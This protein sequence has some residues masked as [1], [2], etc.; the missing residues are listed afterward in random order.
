VILNRRRFLA[1]PLAHLMTR[2]AA[3]TAAVDSAWPASEWSHG[4]AEGSGWDR[5]WL[6]QARDYSR[7]IGTASF[8]LL[9]HGRVIDSWGDTARRIEIH[10]IRKSLLN[11]LIGVAVS[12]G[13]L[14]LDASLASL[15]IDDVPPALSDTEKQATVR[16]LLE[17]RSGVYHRALYETA[18]E[19]RLRPER[20]AHLPGTFWY[21]N[22]WD[23]N[24]LGAIYER[25]VG[26]SIFDRFAEVIA[27][28]LGMQ[29][30]R[31]Q[32]GR[33]VRGPDS[34]FPAYPFHMSARD[35]A[36]FG[37]L[38]LRRGRWRERDI[39]TSDWV[40][41]STT[42]RS[43]TYLHSGYGYM[44]WTGYPDR[45]VD[46]MNLA[47]GGFWADGHNGQFIVVDPSNDLVVLHQTDT[48][49]VTIQQMGHL[50]WLI[51]NASGAT[52]AGHDPV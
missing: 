36:R 23:F 43:E 6:E 14:D 41:D 17:A 7:T 20:G 4:A 30:Y 10:S 47:P 52:D 27:T 37:L 28:P 2:P 49:R 35:L 26:A 16:Q 9:Q 40:R 15:D 39:V 45:R 33:Y 5:A 50:M 22:N 25:A 44:W 13:K 34:N 11:A 12:E 48:A 51:L 38:Y 31:P 8:M 18:G 29:D 21:Y 3:A 1:V 42:A 46:I 32:D 19:K 24:T